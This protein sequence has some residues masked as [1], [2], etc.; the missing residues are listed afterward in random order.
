LEGEGKWW[1][2]DEAIEFHDVS[3]HPPAHTI[4]AH[5]FTISGQAH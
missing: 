1:N 2:K 4:V 5:P 3:N